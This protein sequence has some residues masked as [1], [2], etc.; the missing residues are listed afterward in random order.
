MKTLVTSI[1]LGLISFASFNANAQT[2]A[3]G[4]KKTAISDKQSTSLPAM[5]EMEQ[6][7]ITMVN[8]PEARKGDKPMVKGQGPGHDKG[9]HYGQ[10][11][12]HKGQVTKLDKNNAAHN[13]MKH[14]KNVKG[15]GKHNCQGHSKDGQHD[16]K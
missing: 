10:H 2:S 1:A 8:G 15:K 12:D 11:K 5:Q 7:K 13:K 9:H 6:K 16:R 4:G 3:N 14:G